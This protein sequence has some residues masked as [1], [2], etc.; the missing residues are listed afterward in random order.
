MWDRVMDKNWLNLYAMSGWDK[1][2]ID[3][4]YSPYPEPLNTYLSHMVSTSVSGRL[5]VAIPRIDA[6]KQL[7]FYLVGKNE[8]QA[9]EIFSAVKAYLGSSYTTC[10][11]VTSRSGKDAFEQAVLGMYPKGYKQISIYKACS[12]SQNKDN[13]YWVMNSINLAIEQYYQRPISISSVKRPIGVILRHFFIAVQN[14][15]G[16]DALRLLHELKNH[17]RLSPRNI[18]SLEIQALAAGG[19]WQQILRHSKLDD[20]V[21]GTIPRRL[22]NVLLGSVG[23]ADNN[24][25]SPVSYRADSL[26]LQL[27]GLYP[28][29]SSPPDLENDAAS[30]EKWKLWAIGAVSLGRTAVADQLPSCVDSD[31]IDG[32]RMWAG[33]APLGSSPA[34]TIIPS[35]EEYLDAEI[36]EE[37]AIRLLAE[38]VKASFKESQKIYLRL[39]DYPSELIEGLSADNSLMP[40]LW[41]K[42]QDDHGEQTEIDSWHHLFQKLGDNCSAENA[43]SALTLTIERSEYWSADSWQENSVMSDI[44]KI[45]DNI[46]QGTLRGILPILLKWLEGK[47]KQIPGDAIEHLMILLVS[48]DQ[49]AAE[50]LLLTAGLLLM[51]LNQGHTK[52]QYCNLIECIDECWRK[53]RSPR[54]VDSILEIYETLIDYPCADEGKRMQSW[55]GVQSSLV[56]LWPRLDNQ[57]QQLCYEAAQFI[58]ND[59]SG[60]PELVSLLP[61]NEFASLVDL[62]GKRLAI[63][64]LTEGAGRRAQRILMS[65][66][67]NLEI[68]LNHDKSATSALMN[69]ANTADY[70]VFASRSAAHQ[71][72]YPVS[73][74]RN[75]L[76]YPQGKGA[77]SIVREFLNYLI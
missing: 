22:Q 40:I 35:V 6:N 47:G 56:S 33:I 52:D 69:L 9:E 53:I 28:L 46:A 75:D 23:Y 70:F 13:T 76:I 66:F 2:K 26:S 30:A 36:S 1:E 73:K 17:Q 25:T 63:Y 72:F 45:S 14:Q 68:K 32:L 15:Q 57:Q 11:P 58:V 59:D 61:D 7:H 50:D 27:Q 67:P 74:K 60:L 62:S 4:T 24:S 12:S 21:K 49:I 19:Q 55:I 64:T 48:D 10:D 3:G 65:Y 29:F 8:E 18:L 54:A 31:W 34:Q 51:L 20:L 38:S 39:L 44:E 41:N 16:A 5:P 37:N 43:D 42:L 77:T 71:A